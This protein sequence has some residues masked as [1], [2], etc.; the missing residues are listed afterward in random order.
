ML[1]EDPRLTNPGMQVKDIAE[2]RG[3]AARHAA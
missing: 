2:G 3:A 1:E